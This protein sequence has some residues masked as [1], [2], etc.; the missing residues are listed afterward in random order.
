MQGFLRAGCTA[1]RGWLSRQMSAQNGCFSRGAYERF[2]G[3]FCGQRPTSCHAAHPSGFNALGAV[4]GR[5]TIVEG[6]ERLSWA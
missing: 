1:S 3:Y 5:P 2:A 6:F 4:F